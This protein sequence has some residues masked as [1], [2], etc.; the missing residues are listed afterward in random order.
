MVSQIKV[1]SVLESTSASGVTIDGVLIKDGNVDGVDVSGITSAGLVKLASSTISSNTSAVQ[2]DN[3]RDNATYA[4]YKLVIQNLVLETDNQSLRLTFQS[5]GASPANI[6]GTYNK[7]YNLQGLNNTSTYEGVN[8]SATG[9]QDIMF[10]LRNNGGNYAHQG[11]Y[12]LT[13]SDGTNGICSLV[14][15]VLTMSAVSNGNAHGYT[16]WMMRYG[17]V[18]ATGIKLY[19]QSGNIASGEFYIYGV[20]K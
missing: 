8:Q 12:D 9:Y 15:N 13:M 4:S 2:L 16:I 11:I 14:G 19:S 6:T 18:D 7:A 17:A 20:K 3:F 10:S 5:G 1:D